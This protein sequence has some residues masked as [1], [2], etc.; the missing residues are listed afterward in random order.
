MVLSIRGKA[1]GESHAACLVL[2]SLLVASCSG[3]AAPSGAP[4][5]TCFVPSRPLRPSRP[6]WGILGDY[7]EGRTVQTRRLSPSADTRMMAGGWDPGAGLGGF[8]AGLRKKA[9]EELEQDPDS[10]L[11]RMA[12]SREAGN[13]LDRVLRQGSGPDGFRRMMAMKDRERRAEV[14]SKVE[15][16]VREQD[17]EVGRVK[18]LWV[19]STKE[20]LLEQMPQAEEAGAASEQQ[21]REM[22]RQ[23]WEKRPVADFNAKLE[24]WRQ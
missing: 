17:P 15:E 21:F 14:E 22:E 20:A 11:S 8:L 1:I 5:R 3:T 10:A 18:D 2:L 19:E 16:L 9:V 6:T 4:E 12:R 13:P 24:D 23:A 7:G